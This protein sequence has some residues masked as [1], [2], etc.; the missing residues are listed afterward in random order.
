MRSKTV[1]TV[2]TGLMESN[3]H[4]YTDEDAQRKERFH[5]DAHEFLRSLAKALELPAGS[6]AIR[7]NRGGCAVSGEVTLHA[8]HLY[9]QLFETFTRRGITILYRSCESRQDYTGG[10]NHFAHP[11][12]LKSDSVAQAE[13]IGAC[14]QL[15]VEGMVNTRRL[16]V[17]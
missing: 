8:E 12:D 17:A 14:R 10:R 4:A 15:M 13:F 7:S 2:R 11:E 5:R 1:L 9:V 6:Y 16:A 3:L